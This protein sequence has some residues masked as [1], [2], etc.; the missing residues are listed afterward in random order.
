MSDLVVVFRTQSD[1]EA[2]LVRGLLEG[3]GVPAVVER[4]C[5]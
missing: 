2:T 3:N 4:E 5:E 1:V